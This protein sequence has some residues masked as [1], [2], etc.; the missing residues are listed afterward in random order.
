MRMCSGSY[1]N[2]KECCLTEFDLAAFHQWGVEYE[3]FEAGPGNNTYAIVELP[4][5]QIVKAYV[6][7]IKFL[8]GDGK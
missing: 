5:G 6:E 8:S 4:N 3:E 7:S 1:Y 2:A